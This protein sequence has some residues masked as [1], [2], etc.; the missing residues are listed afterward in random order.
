MQLNQNQLG[1]INLAASKALAD[2]AN[3]IRHWI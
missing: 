3:R 1:H 2:V